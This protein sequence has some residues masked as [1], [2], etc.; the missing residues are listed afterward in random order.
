MVAFRKVRVG[1]ASEDVVAQI[2]QV[3]L[4]GQLSPGD[5]LPSERELAEQ[6]GLSRMTI[7]D[8]LRVLE[9]TGYVEIKVGAGGGAFVREPNF[10]PLSNSLSSMLRFKKATILELAE[11]RKIVETATAELAAKRATA[12]DLEALRQAVETARQSFETGDSLYTPQHSVDFHAALAKAAKNYV[13]D[14][15]VNSFRTLFYRVL[16]E[17]LPTSDMAE[18]AIRDHWAIYQAIEAGDGER[19]RQLM[20]EHLNYFENKVRALGEDFPFEGEAAS[21]PES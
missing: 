5:R 16:E 18:R 13:L 11:A 17:L 10:D 14:L 7:R 21:H 20:T 2:E 4:S 15:T 1:R 8:A 6:F 19:A 9:S 3:I 12:E